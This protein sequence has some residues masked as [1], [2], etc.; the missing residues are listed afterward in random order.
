MLTKLHVYTRRRFN[1]NTENNQVNLEHGQSSA[2]SSQNPSNLPMDSTPLP[3]SDLDILLQSEN[4]LGIE[5]LGHSK[6][7]STVQ[8]EMN[9]LS[10]N[11][12]WEIVD[13]P[14]EKKTAGCKWFFH[15]QVLELERLKKALTREF[16]IKDLGPLRYFLGMEFARSKKETPI[17]P[18]LKLQPASPIEVIDKGKHQHLVRRLICLSHTRLDIAFAAGSVI[19]KRSTLGYCTFVGGNLVTWRSKKQS[20]VAKSSVEAEFR[21]VAHGICEVLWIK[22]LLEELKVASPL[23]IK[24]FCDNNVAIAIAHNLVSP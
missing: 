12:T 10:K 19:D 1:S 11:R 9:A 3:I 14:K 6:W 17:E 22:Q 7:I 20:V 5:A 18:N 4:E 24:V 23:P 21:A 15:N 8:E 2:L 16:E 13:L